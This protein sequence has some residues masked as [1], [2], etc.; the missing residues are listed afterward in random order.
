MARK[1]VQVV[2]TVTIDEDGYQYW[3]STLADDIRDEVFELVRASDAGSSVVMMLVE[4][5]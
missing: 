1:T 5:I 3:P 4:P 2:V